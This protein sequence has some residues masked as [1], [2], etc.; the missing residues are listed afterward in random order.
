MPQNLAV[1]T[2]A[3]LLALS[4]MGAA[5]SAASAA[6]AASL[7]MQLNEPYLF[8]YLQLPLWFLFIAM[9]VLT[10]A[11]AFLSL[12]T[13]Y[14]RARGTK[15]SKFTTALIVGFVISFVVLPTFITEPSP[16][17]MMLTAAVA[18]FSG[19]ILLYLAGRLI[20]NK[21]LH[22][23]VIDLIVHRAIKFLGTVLDLVT[24]HATKLLAVALTSVVASFVIVPQLKT[25]L[26]TSSVWQSAYQEVF[27]V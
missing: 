24:E 26:N 13:D 15:T 3:K 6:N 11:S 12:T 9:I 19:T 1:F 20:S 4:A 8:F 21:E 10:F 2:T 25:E 16:G 22:D 17:L 18:G 23:A 5:A 27:N 14:M 7:N